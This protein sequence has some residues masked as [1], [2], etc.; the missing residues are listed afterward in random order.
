MLRAVL[1]WL[2]MIGVNAAD[3]QSQRVAA[4]IIAAMEETPVAQ[5][6]ESHYPAANVWDITAYPTLTRSISVVPR[7]I[8]PTAGGFLVLVWLIGVALIKARYSLR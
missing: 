5:G 2:A 3:P 4:D 7:W 8:G 6:K 1:Q